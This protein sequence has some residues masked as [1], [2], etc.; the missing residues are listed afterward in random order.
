MDVT[1]HIVWIAKAAISFMAAYMA[2]YM[3]KDMLTEPFRKGER[4]YSMSKGVRTVWPKLEK[5]EDDNIQ[6]EFHYQPDD[7]QLL[8]TAYEEFMERIKKR[9]AWTENGDIKPDS[10]KKRIRYIIKHYKPKYSKSN[11]V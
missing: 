7:S 8:M 3:T 9:Q 5:T 10:G 11:I 4:R 1:S 2:K 6:Y